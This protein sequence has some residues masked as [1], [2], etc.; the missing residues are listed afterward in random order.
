MGE[1]PF[2]VHGYFVQGFLFAGG[3]H[4]VCLVPGLYRLVFWEGVCSTVV[5]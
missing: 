3:G 1:E 2:V 5:G 4:G